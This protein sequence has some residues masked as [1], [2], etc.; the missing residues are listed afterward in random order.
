MHK[1]DNK[2][3]RINCVPVKKMCTLGL[4]YNVASNFRAD[5]NTKYIF[6]LTI[7]EQ[8]GL[9]FRPQSKAQA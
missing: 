9:N 6:E 1:K 5:Y 4:V 3:A 7:H 8:I 2:K